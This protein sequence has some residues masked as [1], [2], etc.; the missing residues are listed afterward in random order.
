MLFYRVF[1]L[2]AAALL[3]TTQAWS[4]TSRPST[5]TGS[6]ASG[7]GGSL[8]GTR[9]NIPGPGPTT[10]QPS[11]NTPFPTQSSQPIFL[12]GKIVLDDGSAPGEPVL[13]ERV[14]AGNQYPE[15]YSDIKG[16]FSI[17]L[18]REHGVFTDASQT[19]APDNVTPSN[20]MGG[21]R[22]RDLIDCD[23][24]ASLAGFRSESVSLATRRYL[25]NPDVGTIVL[26]RVAN[27]GG[28]TISA[29][30]ALAP[31]DARKAYEKGIE[32][33]KK[34]KIDDARKDF[35]KATG[36]YPK[37]ASAW[38]E[39]GRIYQSRKQDEDARKAFHQS[40][41]ADQKYVNPHEGLYMLAIG[42][43]KWQEAAD[44]SD[45]V[46]HLNPYDFPNAYYFN[47]IAN[48]QL[49]NL[50]PAEKSAREA[51]KLDAKGRNPKSNY[52]L[53]I[54]LAQKHQFT[55]AAQYLKT[56]LDKVPGDPNA[57]QIQKQLSGLESAAQQAKATPSK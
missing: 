35:E 31:K 39:L 14:C 46:L 6:N 2:P 4:Q 42:E 18:G 29:T 32:A 48:L 51:V 43:K 56:Y 7:P 27:V 23:L 45:R 47:A 30:S 15:G 8:P 41:A 10:T 49:N 11:I 37:Y 38:F 25:D 17:T 13:I 26:R 36:I 16:R 40:L 19:P 22:E 54:I 24:R 12:T 5:G 34:N 50:D 20:P 1:I 28:L 33:E 53:G 57:P 55:E 9:G 52:V 3:V 44:E 21:V